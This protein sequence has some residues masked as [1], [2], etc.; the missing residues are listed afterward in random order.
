MK[1][2]STLLKD[3]YY[4]DMKS[5]KSTY[6]LMLMV[7]VLK[8]IVRSVMVGA[9]SAFIEGYDDCLYLNFDGPHNSMSILGNIYTTGEINN[10]IY[11]WKEIL[12]LLDMDQFKK[13]IFEKVNA[14]FDNKIWEK[15]PLI[16][17]YSYCNEM[18]RKGCN[19]KRHQL[20]MIW[21][22]KKA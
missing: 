5:L 11:A 21:S 8:F 2:V 7:G 18:R 15:V 4:T 20:M 19:I 14:V 22:F 16:S 1:K 10:K 12:Q 13:V 17:I 9:C 6:Y 3:R